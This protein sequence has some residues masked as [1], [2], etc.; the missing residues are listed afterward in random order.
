VKGWSY[1]LSAFLVIV[2][3]WSD[4]LI[5]ACFGRRYSSHSGVL[6]IAAAGINTESERCHVFPLSTV[7]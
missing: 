6:E 7:S 4:D 3:T 5:N 2:V 1:W